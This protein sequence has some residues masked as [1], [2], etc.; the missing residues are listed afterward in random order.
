MSLEANIPVFLSEITLG[1]SGASEIDHAEDS[2]SNGFLSE[3][4]SLFSTGSVSDEVLWD[5]YGANSNRAQSEEPTSPGQNNQENQDFSTNFNH[6]SPPRTN[7]AE[8]DGD[9]V[10]KGRSIAHS[11]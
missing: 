9:D 11:I 3:Y 5:I 8:F 10:P 7:D 6:Q 4:E 1:R 2:A